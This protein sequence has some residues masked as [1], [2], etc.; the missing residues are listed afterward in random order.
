MMN[1][2]MSE[3]S[4]ASEITTT[5][6][7]HIQTSGCVCAPANCE[8]K[9]PRDQETKNRS[10]A[11]RFAR[12]RDRA[13]TSSS[14]IVEK[15]A[16]S[17]DKMRRRKASRS[18]SPTPAGFLP[19]APETA[20][21]TALETA[22]K[23]APETAPESVTESVTGSAP[24]SAPEKGTAGEPHATAGKVVVGLTNPPAKEEDEDEANK[25]PYITSTKNRFVILGELMDA[26]V[27]TEAA[28]SL[29]KIS[30]WPKGGKIVDNM[31]WCVRARLE[32]CPRS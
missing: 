17:L 15:R 14:A 21:E 10:I 1:T 3:M 2:T 31:S 12:H 26:E 6:E 9:R 28:G 16:M 8:P 25:E 19:D 11:H 20:P 27:A 23:S 13:S 7:K 29:D 22:P 24:E 30:G 4:K 18:R 32:W 5:S